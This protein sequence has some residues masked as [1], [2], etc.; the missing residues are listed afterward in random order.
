MS[1]QADAQH[2]R[3]LLVGV[4]LHG[5]TVRGASSLERE[6]LQAFG[7]IV[8][9]VAGFSVWQAGNPSEKISF[10]NVSARRD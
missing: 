10:T 4:R 5:I 3:S 9:A 8:D 2:H 1:I 7:E 6:V